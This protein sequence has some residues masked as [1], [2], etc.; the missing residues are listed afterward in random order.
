[1][2]SMS[3]ARN[4]L[5]QW[6]AYTSALGGHAIGFRGEWLAML[7]TT[8]GAELVKVH[9]GNKLINEIFKPLFDACLEQWR[10][11]VTGGNL[12]LV[13]NLFFSKMSLISRWCKDDAFEE[14]GGEWRLICNPARAK[15]ALEI[16]TRPRGADFVPYC[17]IGFSGLLDFEPSEDAAAGI[18]DVVVGPGL[19]HGRGQVGVGYL[20]RAC[21]LKGKY[22]LGQ[23]V[24]RHIGLTSGLA[25]T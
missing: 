14:E 3:N 19:D 15:Q 9:Y 8:V 6:R 4:K 18:F 22:T 16:H 5:S 23:S 13:D 2:F 21:G 10:A 1:M 25:L 20:M 24:A 12:A 17:A 7:A 11:G